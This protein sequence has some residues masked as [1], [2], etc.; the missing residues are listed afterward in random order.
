M[1][2]RADEPEISRFC[3]AILIQQNMT[4]GQG[5]GVGSEGEKKR[6]QKK[7]KKQLSYPQPRDIH[8]ETQQ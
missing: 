6:K 7:K 4:E 2:E 8:K 1:H 3:A 5:Q